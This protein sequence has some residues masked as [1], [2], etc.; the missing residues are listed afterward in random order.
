M[1]GMTELLLASAAF[2]GTH[3]AM[4]H[5]LRAPMVSRLGENGFRGVYSLVSFITLAWMAYAYHLAA[6]GAPLWPGGDG[7]WIVATA[8]MWAASV[9]LVGSLARNPALPD[10]NAARNLDRPA[11][12]VFAI[13]RHPMMWGF[14]LWGGA[15][16][17]AMPTPAQI[18]LAGA[19]V[20]LAL[21]GARGQDKKKEA[22]MGAG[23]QA[24][25]ARTSYWPFA[26]QLSGRTGWRAA[27]PDARTLLIGTVLWLGLTY[28]HGS[29]GAGIWRWLG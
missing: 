15:H 25:E 24:W 12:G 6:K 18:V 14:A 9:L 19:I 8:L 1:E 26:L 7:P 10:P 2:V 3:M 17:I 11:T 28:A 5:P 22:L 23:W 29:I 4:S 21:V 16:I 20:L 13:T 27:M